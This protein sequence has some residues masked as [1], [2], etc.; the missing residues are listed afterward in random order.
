[1]VLPCKSNSEILHASNN[2][3]CSSSQ[4][5]VK[6]ETV[7]Q[8]SF[9]S[10][11]TPSVKILFVQFLQARFAHQSL[12]QSSTSSQRVA[13]LCITNIKKTLQKLRRIWT[14]TC[15]LC[16][17][18]KTERQHSN[19]KLQKEKL[20]RRYMYLTKFRRYTNNTILCSNVWQETWSRNHF[21]VFQTH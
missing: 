21:H 19:I 3:F 17:I 16:T 5:L 9:D 8:I 2:L 20:Y 7:H 14:I 6:D 4:K 12:Q 18:W 11:P 1:M 15:N 10:M 13:L